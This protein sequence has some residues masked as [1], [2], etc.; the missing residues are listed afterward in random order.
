MAQKGL[1][2]VRNLAGVAI[3]QHPISHAGPTTDEARA[4]RAQ[5]KS[6]GWFNE[7]FDTSI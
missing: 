4:A 6:Y 2:P 7:G 1:L 3:Q 5:A